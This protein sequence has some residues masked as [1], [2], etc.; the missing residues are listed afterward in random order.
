MTPK[1]IAE[2]LTEAQ[3]IGLTGVSNGY[4]VDGK[5]V[6]SHGRKWNG[7]AMGALRRG[8]LVSVRVYSAA[9]YSLTPLG[10]AVAEKLEGGDG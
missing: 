6:C 1:A 10:R 7:A 9:F 8:G 2:S 5:W 4:S 3:R